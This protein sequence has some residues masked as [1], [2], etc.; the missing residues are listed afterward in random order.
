MTIR[1]NPNLGHLHGIQNICQ[2]YLPRS[3][4]RDDIAGDLWL[5]Y[6][7][8]G[9]RH[10]NHFIKLQAIKESQ[11]RR[12]VGVDQQSDCRRNPRADFYR[13]HRHEDSVDDNEAI[14][15]SDARI[16]LHTIIKICGLT[17]KELGILVRIAHG[18]G[19]REIGKRYGMPQSCVSLFQKVAIKK[20][21][22]HASSLQGY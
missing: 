6:W 18:H 3:V 12:Y 22:V 19:Q 11:R 20:L 17:L 14:R 13:I 10:S 4:D 8:S 7:K 21:R 16:D 9:A 5:R 1:D 2:S 15:R